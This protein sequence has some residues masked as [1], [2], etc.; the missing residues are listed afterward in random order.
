M[1]VNERRRGIR[2]FGVAPKAGTSR[3][4]SKAEGQEPPCRPPGLEGAPEIIEARVV[5]GRPLLHVV[6][7]VMRCTL[8]EPPILPCCPWLVHG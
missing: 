5:D 2:E 3:G 4:L 1:V 8:V 6:P 7:R